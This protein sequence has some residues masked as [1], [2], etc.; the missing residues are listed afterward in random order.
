[1]RHLGRYRL[2]AV[3]GVG[4]FAT[5]WR[6]YDTD[7]EVQVAVK[8]LADNWV[9]H[10][11]V[12]ERFLAE[13]RLLR[14]IDDPR[15]V[16]V[17]DVG[18]AD[19]RPY[20][21]MDFLPG[22]TL[23]DVIATGVGRERALALAA[24][25]ARAVQVLHDAGVL[26]RDVKPSNL[27]LDADGQVVVSD[28]GSAKRLA[29]ASGITVTTGTPAYM[30]PEQAFGQPLDARCD[31]HALGVLAYELVAGR[32]P[33]DGPV[34]RSPSD[35]PDPTEAGAGV[36]RVLAAATAVRP[37]DRPESP[38]RLAEAIETVDDTPPVRTVAP[39]LVVLMM[40]AGF[41]AAAA[42]VWWLGA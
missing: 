39:S 25:S 19:D 17:H 9:H 10:T 13:A 30:A 1:M 18:I 23:A 35:R 33:F 41:V 32:L 40:V 34:G 8:V 20:F 2:D 24:E 11:D 4:A 42:G 37:S 7:L 6:G 12:R 38:G 28:L 16:R 14:R 36:D 21:V 29:E 26:H 22:G 3:E 15:V 27:L 5:V 31:V